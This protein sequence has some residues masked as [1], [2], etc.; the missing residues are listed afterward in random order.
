MTAMAMR[1]R[2]NTAKP[3][4]SKKKV[5]QKKTRNTPAEFTDAAVKAIFSAYP[6]PLKTKLLALRRLIFDVARTTQGI[7]TLEET[8]KWGQPSYLTPETGSGTTVRIDQVK[9]TAGQY[10]VYFH[11]Q[12]DLVE[13]FRGLY[14]TELNYG[15]NRSILLS[16]ADDVPEAA[17][18]HC[19]GLALTYH[20]N[21]RKAARGV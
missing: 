6:K 4:T 15:G 13:T 18:R 20:L 10:A 12:T 16:A 14:P 5:P 2:A 8:L 3:K 17:L 21:K 7:G 11:C 1:P 19:I 9:S